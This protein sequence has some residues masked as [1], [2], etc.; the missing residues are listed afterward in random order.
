MGVYARR[1]CVLLVVCIVEDI[2]PDYYSKTMIGSLVDLQVF[3]ELVRDHLPQ[4]HEHILL[5]VGGVVLMTVPWFMCMFIH[6][7]PW[8]STFRALDLIFAEGSRALSVI[9]LAVFKS[10]ERQILELEGDALLALLKEN[11]VH[12]LPTGELQK[13]IKMYDPIV[14]VD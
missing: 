4:V 7:L 1:R 3:D 6:C 11:L 10:C 14:T 13:N 2:L 8:K 12:S 5:S 9:G